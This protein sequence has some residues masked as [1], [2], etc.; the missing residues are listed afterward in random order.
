[1]D[2]VE[3]V[4]PV[5]ERL[6]RD[7][8]PAACITAVPGGIKLGGTT[9]CSGPVAAAS[10]AGVGAVNSS[11]TATAMPRS[12]NLSTSSIASSEWPP[13][14]KKLSSAPTRSSPS[15]WAN[16]WHAISSRTV[17][18]PRPASSAA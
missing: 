3:L 9:T 5:E 12:R 13:S 8:E 16:T 15:T 6:D 1:M 11:R 18:G 2:E 7:H 4:D 17:T 14:S 10:P